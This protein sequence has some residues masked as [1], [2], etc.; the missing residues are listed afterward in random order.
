MPKGRL[1]DVLRHVRGLVA[2]RQ[3]RELAD[4]ELL[5]RFI[6]DRDEAAFAAIVERH[7]GLVAG[8][9]R[10]ILSDQHFVEDASQATFLVLARKAASIRKHES[11]GSWLHGVACRVSRKL[12]AD[13]QRRAAWDVSAADVPCPDATAEITWREGLAVFHEELQRLPATYRTALVLC[14]L[15]GRSQDEVATELGCS[16]AALR[17]RLL[18]ARECLRRRLVR[19]G[20]GLGASVLGAVLVSTHVAVALPPAL[21]IGVTKATAKLL[22]GHDLAQVVPARV[23]TLTEGVLTAMSATRLKLVAALV[24]TLCLLTVGA[25][26]FAWTA[27]GRGQTPPAKGAAPAPAQVSP[28]KPEGVAAAEPASRLES[29][30]ADLASPDEAKALRAALALAASSEAVPFLKAH[31]KPVKADP[32]RVA[33]LIG[34]LGNNAFA[35]RMAAT[36][37]LDYLGRFIKADL[38]RALAKDLELEVK[39]RLQELLKRIAEELGTPASEPPRNDF[40]ASYTKKPDLV[41][42][43]KPTASSPPLPAPRKALVRMAWVRAA[44]A[45]A[46]LEHFGTPEARQI[47]EVLA[48]GESEAPPTKAAKEALDRLKN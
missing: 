32:Q 26:A 3:T 40:K 41:T 34:D 38:E 5:E 8:V 11:L 10:Q 43:A 14:Y 36:A 13:V 24:L 21:A 44:R 6:Q 7:G 4:R 39:M 19:R 18:R 15:E 9:C 27:P 2:A 16:P 45:V 12:R 30:W 20:M 42:T 29:L 48:E 46:V 22:A 25:G 1:D 17:G 31:L 33:Q 28:G 23:A 47:L 35:T 37:E